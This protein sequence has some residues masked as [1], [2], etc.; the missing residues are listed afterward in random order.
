MKKSRYQSWKGLFQ[1]RLYRVVDT[2]VYIGICCIILNS[3]SPLRYVDSDYQLPYSEDCN[4]LISYL[5]DYTFIGNTL[6]VVDGSECEVDTVLQIGERSTEWVKKKSS[7][8]FST[9]PDDCSVWCK[10]DVPGSLD[11]LLIS[12]YPDACSDVDDRIVD[13][14][15]TYKRLILRQ[16]PIVCDEHLDESFY[17]E[18]KFRISQIGL[19]DQYDLSNSEELNKA[20]HTYQRDHL[21]IQST[22]GYDFHTLE[23]LGFKIVK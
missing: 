11:T 14:K 7:N 22:E 15:L 13:T 5:E 12:K 19:G 4:G 20:F 3:C 18:L 10:V 1:N 2:L 6:P 21:N 8:C 9:D 23:N 17:E 16:T